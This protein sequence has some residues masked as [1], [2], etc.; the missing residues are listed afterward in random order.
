MRLLLCVHDLET[1]IHVRLPDSSS[2]FLKCLNRILL[3]FDSQQP[4]P[5]QLPPSL[6]ANAEI[7]PD[8]GLVEQVDVDAVTVPIKEGHLAKLDLFHQF[9]AKKISGMVLFVDIIYS[10]VNN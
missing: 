8:G 1:R 2:V 7:F 9:S 4:I 6:G 3:S 5:D 10:T